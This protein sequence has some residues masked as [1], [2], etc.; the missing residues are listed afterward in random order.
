MIAAV[1]RLSHFGVHKTTL[2]EIAE[3]LGMSTQALLYY[4]ADKQTLIK[5][6]LEYIAYGYLLSLSKHMALAANF[7]EALIQLVETRYEY[8]SRYYMIL[9]ELIDSDPPKT[10]D[11]LSLKDYLYQKERNILISL[12]E[13]AMAMKEV[14]GSS[15]SQVVQLVQETLDA[16]SH[17]VNRSHRIPEEGQMKQ[18]MEK[19]KDVIKLMYKGIAA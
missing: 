8:F 13:D 18:L 2:G 1:K 6:V 14:K 17:S 5:A 4:F 9:C 11:L 16:F 3:D 7:E 12:F 19:Q 10:S 15:A